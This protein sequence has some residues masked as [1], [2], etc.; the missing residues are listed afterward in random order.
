MSDFFIHHHPLV[1]IGGYEAAIGGVHG[2]FLRAA[3]QV[4]LTYW[5]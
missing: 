4:V 2:Y 5:A 3:V 1:H